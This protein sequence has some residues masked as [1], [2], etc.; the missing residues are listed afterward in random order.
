M[1]TANFFRTQCERSTSQR[2]E[3]E[4]SSAL[5]M[6]LDVVAPGGWYPR[7][8]QVELLH[9]L[10]SIRGQSEAAYGDLIRCGGAMLTTENEF[11][12]LLMKVMTPDLFVKKVPVFWSRDH[13]NGGTCEVESLDTT[14][15]T[16]RIRLRGVAGYDHF[17]VVWLGWMKR[18]LEVVSGPR[19]E[20]WQTGWSWS[21]PGPEDVSI[22]VRW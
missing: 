7:Q 11:S 2:F 4:L 20:V 6:E 19:A 13:R 14:A 17:T 21:A 10:T 9:T 22:E 16:G 8:H 3:S 1:H 15:R 5:R 12:R 18:V